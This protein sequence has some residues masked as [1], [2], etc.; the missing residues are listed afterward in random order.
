MRLIDPDQ[1]AAPLV[2]LAERYEA[3]TVAEHRHRRAQLMYAL[4]GSMSV[5]TQAGSWVLPPNRALFIPAGFTHA[6]KVQKPVE[7]RTLYIGGDLA[8]QMP[9]V[10]PA[11]LPVS[12]LLRELI[13]A[14]VAADW[15]YGKTSASARL[16]R[17][18][19]DQLCKVGAE[20]VYLPEPADPRA[21]RLARIYHSNPAERRPLS[22][23]ARQAG[24]G[25]RTLERLFRA[26]TGLTLGSWVQQ[27]RL[28]YALQ[29]LAD[30][31]QV[32]DAAFHV[33]FENPSSFIALFKK[34]FG[35]TPAQYF[36]DRGGDRRKS[37][38]E[39]G[40]Q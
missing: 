9:S 35:T 29:L 12:A 8:G 38:S 4:D 32:G 22:V 7:L 11:V 5:L 19:C 6:L 18:L 40:L 36:V 23:L 37:S 13:L 30:G 24:A 27:L 1:A 16:A 21:Q 2:G 17:V 34:Q 14:A 20:P 39:T 26:E 10:A 15:N 33:G 31:E 28:L 25:I 3:C